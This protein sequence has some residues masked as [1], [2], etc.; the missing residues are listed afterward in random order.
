MFLKVRDDIDLKELEKFGFELTE[1]TSVYC[2]KDSGKTIETETKYQ[3]YCAGDIEISIEDRI[4]TSIGNWEDISDLD[5]FLCK[6]FDL[7]KAGIL[8]KID[9]DNS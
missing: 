7:T 5:T 6:I 8:E 2:Y 4:V 3:Y 9:K 1:G